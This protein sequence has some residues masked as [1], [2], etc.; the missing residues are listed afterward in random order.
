L[1]EI[2]SPPIAIAFGELFFSPPATKKERTGR[3]DA[4]ALMPT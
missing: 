2:L 4:Q 3:P 1:A